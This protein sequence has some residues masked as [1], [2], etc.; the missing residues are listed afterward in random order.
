MR[1]SEK[2]L[3]CPIQA[4]EGG[5][6][7]NL[8][9]E[10]I[11]AIEGRLGLSLSVTNLEPTTG[12]RELSSVQASDADRTRVKDLLMENL[13]KQ[14]REKF[15]NELNSGDMLFENTLT[16]SQNFS[17]DYDPPAGA[18]GTK[19]TFTMQVEFSVRYASASDLTELATLA[20]NAALPSGF[21]CDPRHSD[22]EA[23][24][25]SIPCRGWLPALDDARR[26]KDRA[27]I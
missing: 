1:V 25:E 16:V 19:L 20:M 27:N 9:A 21:L 3:S 11:N 24:D 8:D 4:V 15:L 26:A 12:G 6:A 23:G 10:T 5:V 13:A 18:A 7:G 22:R 14:A 2:D 17:E